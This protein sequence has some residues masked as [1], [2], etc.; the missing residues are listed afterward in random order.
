VTNAPTRWFRCKHDGAGPR[1]R[2]I[3]RERTIRKGLVGSEQWGTHASLLMAHDIANFSE[4]H[5][6]GG[7][8]DFCLLSSWQLLNTLTQTEDNQ[9]AKT[10][11]SLSYQRQILQ[12]SDV[13]FKPDW[14]HNGQPLNN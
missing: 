4:R 12:P 7:A 5:R 10:R 14:V 3:D 6:E 13:A 1:D 11:K 9:N 2:A 8:K